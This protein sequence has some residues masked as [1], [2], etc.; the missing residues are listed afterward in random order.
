MALSDRFHQALSY[1]YELHKDQYRKD[2]ITPY[3]SHLMAVSALALQYSATEDEAIAALLHDAVEDQGG[4]ETLAIIRQQFGDHVAEIVLACSDR[5]GEP[6]PPWQDRK[7]KY[8]KHLEK[9]DESSLLVTCCDKLHN[10]TDCLRT[11]RKIGTGLWQMFNATKE[12]THWYYGEIANVIKKR[13]DEY[14]RLT[15]LID[16]VVRTIDELLALP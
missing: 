1:A 3:L 7:E 4:L 13:R 6:K 5:E 14:P 10:A 9:T 16:D 12:Q 8:L 2:G 15:N 11:H